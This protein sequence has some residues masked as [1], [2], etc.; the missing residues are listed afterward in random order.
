MQRTQAELFEMQTG[1]PPIETYEIIYNRQYENSALWIRGDLN[2]YFATMGDS[3][4][5]PKYDTP[6]EV[7]ELLDKRDYNILMNMI[8]IIMDKLPEIK[9]EDEQQQ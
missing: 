5:T 3:I 6:E 4:I 1:K 7:I 8:C 2:Q 9:K